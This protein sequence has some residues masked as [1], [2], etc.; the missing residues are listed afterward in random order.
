MGQITEA[1]LTG[2]DSGPAGEGDAVLAV[3]DVE[4]SESVRSGD[5]ISRPAN[6][7]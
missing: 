2:G 1:R 6:P 4:R 3:V 5:F 7:Y